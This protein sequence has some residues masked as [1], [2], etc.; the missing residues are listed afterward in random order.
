MLIINYLHT[1]L[2]FC[3]DRGVFYNSM[4]VMQQPQLQFS[5]EIPYKT[6]H[7]RQCID[8]LSANEFWD[9]KQ[10]F[11]MGDKHPAIED[12]FYLRIENKRPRWVTLEQLEAH[13][14][15]NRKWIEENPEKNA[16]HNRRYYRAN[17][18]KVATKDRKYREAN[19]EKIAAKTAKYRA[20]KRA[21]NTDEFG[22]CTITDRDNKVFEQHQAHAKRLRD[23]LGV[24]F[25]VNHIFPTNNGG[26]HKEGNWQ[27]IPGKLNH[28]IS[29]RYAIRWGA[30]YG[31]KE[32]VSAF[33][34]V[35]AQ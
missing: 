5:S 35:I 16:A 23:C 15:Y 30:P 12:L 25:E 3:F 17:P 7:G 28:Q 11:K 1:T 20:Q 29:D 19:P 2:G 26:A 9:G 31:L 34:N 27:V 32:N 4:A 24:N 8:Q 22:N 14:E 13:R 6:H 18:E 21:N 10:K 33:D